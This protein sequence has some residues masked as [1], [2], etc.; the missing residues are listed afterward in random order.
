MFLTIL[1]L[2]LYFEVLPKQV[3][4]HGLHV[5][6]DATAVPRQ[7]DKM[8]WSVTDRISMKTVRVFRIMFVCVWV[9]RYS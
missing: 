2:D 1:E 8:A 5:T 9:A 7:R 6:T 3:H 4:Y